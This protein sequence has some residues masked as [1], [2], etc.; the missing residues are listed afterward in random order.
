M[1]MSIFQHFFFLILKKNNSK[2]RNISNISHNI[3]S[4]ISRLLFTI[5]NSILLITR[6]SDSN[7][8]IYI[9]F[10]CRTILGK[11]NQNSF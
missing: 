3:I 1:I 9:S 11:M 8:Y 7:I 4:E 5:Q 10:V 2:N 6:R